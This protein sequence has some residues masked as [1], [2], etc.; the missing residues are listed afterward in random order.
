MA[1]IIIPKDQYSMVM[2]DEMGKLNNIIDPSNGLVAIGGAPEVKS[3]GKTFTWR[4]QEALSGNFTDITSETTALTPTSLDQLGIVGVQQHLGLPK[5]VAK[6][7]S[8]LVGADTV[9]PEIVK[10]IANL[11]AQEA[12]LRMASCTKG[13]FASP[14]ATPFITDISAIG[15]GTIS[16]K[17]IIDTIAAKYPEKMEG[18]LTH[19]IMHPLQFA[20]LVSN[21]AIEYK[22]TEYGAGVSTQGGL[23]FY[24]GLR[25]V[26]NSVLCTAIVEDGKTKYPV[27]LAAPKAF[28]LDYQRDLEILTQEDIL[29]GGG[30]TNIAAYMSLFTSFHAG[31]WTGGDGTATTVANLSNG[32]NWEMKYFDTQNVKLHMIKTILKV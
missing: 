29:T 32:A 12:Q 2:L 7:N 8:I 23:P 6:Y 10:N 1:T 28:N 14:T 26:T 17:A 30:V 20:E 4:L 3:G 11:A 9:R 27:Y 16:F 18:Y 13:A 21:Q 24:C 19:I 15:D 25:V 5:F 31:S 22:N